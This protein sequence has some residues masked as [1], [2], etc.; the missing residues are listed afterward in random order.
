M[1]VAA[2][3]R[4]AI[5]FSLSPVQVH[6]APEGRR[7]LNLLVRQSDSSWLIVD[8]AY[9]GAKIRQPA[10]A[11]GYKPVMPRRRTR[12]APWKYDREMYKRRNQI[13]WLFRQLKGFLLLFSRFEKFDLI[14]LGF[15]VFA[16]IINSL[17]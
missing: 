1:T 13:E 14:K 3:D 12:R 16:R 7:L 15:I 5:A 9:E 11:L 17:R 8:R 2:K 4:T 10:L 6:D